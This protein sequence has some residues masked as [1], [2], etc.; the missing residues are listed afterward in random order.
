MK[1]PSIDEPTS[2]AV[3]RDVEPV[4]HQEASVGRH[5]N[6]AGSGQRYVCLHVLQPIVLEIQDPIAR[7]QPQSD[8]G[9][10]QA[11]D[12]RVEVTVGKTAVAIDR[13]EQIWLPAGS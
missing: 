4:L 10:C 3:L 9:V 5:P 13:R 1:L 8:Q 6:E 11:S 12:P 2:S 7:P